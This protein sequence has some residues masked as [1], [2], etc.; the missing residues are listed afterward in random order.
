MLLHLKSCSSSNSSSCS[1]NSSSSSSRSSSKISS[2]SSSSKSSRSSS[3]NSSSRRSS[4]SSRSAKLLLIRLMIATAHYFATLSQDDE[5][6][7]FL[8]MILVRE[9]NVCP[10]SLLFFLFFCTCAFCKLSTSFICLVLQ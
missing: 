4:R 1:F 6:D 7:L 5:Y 10:L 8:M 2:S 9:Y 3:S